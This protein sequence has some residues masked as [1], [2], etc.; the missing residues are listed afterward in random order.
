MKINSTEIKSLQPIK[1][2]GL[3]HIGDYQ[4]IGSAFEK[5]SAW[6]G[7]NNLWVASPRMAAVYHNDPAKTPVDELRSMACL[8]NLSNLQPTEGMDLYIISGGKYFVMQVEVT[9]AE[10]GDAWE[11]ADATF[12][13]QGYEWDS[14]DCYE[15]YV[16]CKGDCQDPNSI[17][18]VDIC[19][20]VK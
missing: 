12:L 17:W 7:S 11:K 3:T 6:A 20:P 16:S 10:Y 15:L 2:I 13:E 1:T 9:M 14:R 4:G 8:E 18:L 19:I 5:L